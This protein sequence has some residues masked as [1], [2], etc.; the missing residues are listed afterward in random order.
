L[1]VGSVISKVAAEVGGSGGGHDVAA[2][3][4]ISRERMDEFIAKLDQALSEAGVT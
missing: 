1:N 3:A 2:A 4:R